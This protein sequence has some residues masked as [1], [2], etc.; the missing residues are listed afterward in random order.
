MLNTFKTVF[1][2]IA[3][4]GLLSG[5]S[6][7]KKKATETPPPAATSEAPVSTGANLD[8]LKAAADAAGNVFYFEFDSFVLTEQTRA[9]LLAHAEY[10]KAAPRSLR[11]EGHADERGS[12]EYNMALGEKRAAAVKDFLASQGVS[13][14][15]EVVSFGEEQPAEKGHAEGSWSKN[16]RVELK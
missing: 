4:L 9:A 3:V 7:T 11:L 8:A 13:S 16:R 14:A 12:R 6:S 10:L 15:V 1:A 2:L 5:C